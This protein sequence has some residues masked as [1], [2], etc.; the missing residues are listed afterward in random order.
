MKN[1]P[2]DYKEI[3]G[4]GM[5]ADPENEPT[6]P[7]KN[8]TGDDHKR[9]NYERS[10]QQPINVE[11]LKSTERPAP[12]VVFGDTAPPSGLSGIIRRYA[13]KHSEDRYRHWIPLILADRINV[14][15]GIIEDTVTGKLPNLFKEKGWS[16]EW[17]FD[18][19]GV[20]KK[21]ATVGFIAALAITY[22][23]EKRK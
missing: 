18:K 5:D 17:K 13:F 21:A 3:P 8:Y 10:P 15:E 7:M 22:F 9:I 6:Y 16:Q 1:Q 12:S 11:L 4:W 23:R 20:A 14:Y 19:L 2:F